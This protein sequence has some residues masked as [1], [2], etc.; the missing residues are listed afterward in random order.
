MEEKSKQKLMSE[1]KSFLNLETEKLN[2]INSNIFEID[3]D[4]ILNIKEDELNNIIEKEFK[5]NKLKKLEIKKI[6]IDWL[7]KK[8]NDKTITT[9]IKVYL[10][11]DLE[12][13]NY[14]PSFYS[15]STQINNIEIKLKNNHIIYEFENINDYGR[16][17]S[18]KEL[19][20]KIKCFKDI[21]MEMINRF[22]EDINKFNIKI[23]QEIKSEIEKRRK[24]ILKNNKIFEEIKTNLEF[25]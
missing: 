19:Q 23:K 6:D 5:K 22:N 14:R 2:K 11:G 24:N 25:K 13:L 4:K 20:E 3:K 1:E 12:V 7:E 9:I 16:V 17:M 21:L 8:D 18:Q 15:I 10:E